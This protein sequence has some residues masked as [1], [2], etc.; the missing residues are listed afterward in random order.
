MEPKVG[1]F[2]PLTAMLAFCAG[3]ATAEA[4][5][6]AIIM[7]SD[8]AGYNTHLST[9]YWSGAAQPYDSG[10]FLEMPVSTYNLRNGG[11]P[12]GD[13]NQDP[14]IVYD[15]ARAWD[16]TPL[17]PGTDDDR[18]GYEDHFRGYQWLQGTSP[19]SAGTMSAM[20]TGEKVYTGGVNVDAAGSPLPTVPEAAKAAGKATGSISSVRYNHATPAAGGGAHNVARGNYLDIS[21][22]LF[23]AGVLDVVGG[24]GHPFYNANG[25]AR[26]DGGGDPD[27]DFGS[28]RFNRPLWD[29]LFTGT[30]SASRTTVDGRTFTVTGAAWELYSDRTDIEELAD[31]VATVTA[32]RKLAMIPE[33]WGTLQ[34]ERD[35]TQDWDGNGTIR[36]VDIRAAPVNPGDD[37]TGDPFISTVPSLASM[38]RAA[39]N[40]LDDDPDGFYL[41]VEGGA[42]DWAMHGNSMGRMIEEHTAFN[43]AV[44]AVIDY[45]DADTHGNNW[46]NTLLIV[47]SDH[48]HNLYGPDSDTIAF[49]E[50]SDNG[51]GDLPGHLWHDNSHGNQLVPAW[52]RGPGA[53]RVTDL[54]DGIDPVRGPYIDQVDIGRILLGAV[55]EPSSLLLTTLGAAVALRRRSRTRPRQRDAVSAPSRGGGCPGHGRCPGA[56]ARASRTRTATAGVAA[57]VTPG[58]S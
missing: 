6:N 24:P 56:G 55:P 13:F 40:H 51:A 2:R 8:G 36:S 34:Y 22:E 44:Q 39:L 15:I 46:S 48:D 29:T 33:V 1:R 38:T 9:R 5:K 53:D 16:A 28:N 19:D 10:N 35:V 42:C 17:P 32:G 31:G 45:L 18:D 12:N 47:T 26:L 4:A 57:W 20:M 37:A 11:G 23:G 43:D 41:H 50:V 52:L 14:D 21:F 27:P 30:G 3:A 7:I 25:S 58:R 54:S 49:Q